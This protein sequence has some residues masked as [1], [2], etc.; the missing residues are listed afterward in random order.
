MV[1]YIEDSILALAVGFERGVGEF[2][3]HLSMPTAESAS[4]GANNA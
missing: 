2:I 1:K 4:P 3:T